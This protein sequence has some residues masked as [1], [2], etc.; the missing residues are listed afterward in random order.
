MSSLESIVRSGS[1]LIRS[2][3]FN[4]KIK[5]LFVRSSVL[6]RKHR[7]EFDFDCPR[8]AIRWSAAGFPDLLTRHML[9]EGMYQQ[10]V[11][12]AMQNLLRPADVVFDVG[13]HH[14]LMAIVAAKA[15]GPDG[16]VV[17]FEPNPDARKFLQRHL[18]LNKCS[19]VKVESV[20]LSDRDAGEVQFYVQRGL[21]SWN[22]TMLREFVPCDDCR[23]L[24]V[25]TCTLDG[26]VAA[27]G[28][29]PALVKI[30]V[31]G[32]EFIILKG[33][34]RTIEQFR[35]VLIVEFN[36]D[37]AR[38]ARVSIPDMADNLQSQ[39]YQL[40]ALGRNL[41]GYYEFHRRVPFHARNRQESGTLA[42]IICVP[43]PKAVT[44]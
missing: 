20:A 30:D 38:A 15:V 27:T 10:D 3:P 36:P 21:V 9:F 42:N 8:L 41:R 37:S 17:A 6:L 39:G 24:N 33:A 2:I 13:S 34:R 12:I 35:P 32:A 23:T 29:I 19:G 28:R 44:R 31:E 43:D 40:Y 1:N 16:M 11:L 4:R 18:Q 22:S 5:G 7:F 14:G 26:Y 25:P